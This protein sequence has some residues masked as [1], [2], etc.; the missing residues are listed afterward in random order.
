MLKWLIPLAGVAVVG[1]AVASP[2]A[3][4]DYTPAPARITGELT[5]DDD[6]DAQGRRYD[7]YPVELMR[8]QQVAISVA[9]APGSLV[10]PDLQIFRHGAATPDVTREAQGEARVARTN[11]TASQAGVFVIR[12]VAGNPASGGYTLS[13]RHIA[14]GGGVRGFTGP[15]RADPAPPTPTDQPGT[16][17]AGPRSRFIVCPGHPRCPR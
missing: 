9:P 3:A 14:P 8:G 1:L 6:A 11:L 10:A 5:A 4:Q 2:A 13:L 17:I 16:I 7:E 12:V 15:P